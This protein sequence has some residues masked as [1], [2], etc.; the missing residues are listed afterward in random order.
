MN[1][2]HALYGI[3]IFVLLRIPTSQRINN[4]I[5]LSFARVFLSMIALIPILSTESRLFVF[6]LFFCCLVLDAIV[7][8]FCDDRPFGRLFSAVA[9]VVL[10]GM[11]LGS[12]S[13][14]LEETILMGYLLPG[15]DQLWGIKQETVVIVLKHLVGCFIA[16]FVANDFVLGMLGASKTTPSGTGGGNGMG[17]WIGHLE[18]AIMYALLVTGN[19][20]AITFVIA[21]K[22]LA[23][24][25]EL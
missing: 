24:F 16:I 23:R 22:A 12:S 5:L 10:I 9:S 11:I 15:L 20:G 7:L 13:I 6:S 2:C 14:N 4:P 1:T 8:F 3:T 19:F 17:R 21:A 25:K 18:R